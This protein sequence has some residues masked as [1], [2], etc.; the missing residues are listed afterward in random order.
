MMSFDYYS[1]M[2]TGERLELAYKMVCEE[3]SKK[4]SRYAVLRA[5]RI[6]KKRF[7]KVNP[8]DAGIFIIDLVEIRCFNVQNNGSIHT[9]KLAKLERSKSK[10]TCKLHFR[11]LS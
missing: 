8:H 10:G 11:R 6:L 2:P 1:Q 9:W 5:A 4:K 3:L 7:K